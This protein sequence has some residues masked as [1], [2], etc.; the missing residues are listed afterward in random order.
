[1]PHATGQLNM[2][3]L[4]LPSLLARARALKQ[5]KPPQEGACVRNYGV[6]SAR[7]S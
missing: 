7:H 5:E 4:H 6:A 1:M 2:R 3:A